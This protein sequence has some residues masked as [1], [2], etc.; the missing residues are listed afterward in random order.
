VASRMWSPARFEAAWLAGDLCLGWVRRARIGG[1]SWGPGEPPHEVD[2]AYRVVVSDAGVT[3]RT[4]DVEA[5][6]AVYS[7][8]EQAADFPS[9]GTASIAVAQLGA[10]GEPGAWSYL[11]VSLAAP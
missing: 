7:A 8:A 10:D 11:T 9:G 5:G 4:W 2:E 1:D 3:Q 6:G